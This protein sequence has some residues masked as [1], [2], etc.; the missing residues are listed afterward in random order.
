[1]RASRPFPWTTLDAV[2]RADVEVLPVVRRA[3]T[4]L[5]DPAA[6]SAA[7]RAL[8]GECELDARLRRV[9]S[10]PPRVEQSAVGMLLAPAE[11]ADRSSAIVVVLEHALAGALAARALKRQ[12]PRVVDPERQSSAA[13][14]GAAAAVLVAAARR[15]GRAPL[16][17]L[18]AGGAHAVLGELVAI[19][20]N[21]VGVTLTVLLDHDAYLAHA[22]FPRQA[23]GALPPFELDVRGLAGLGGLPVELRLVAAVVEI[24]PDDLAALRPGDALV[25]GTLSIAPGNIGF[26]GSVL[27]VAPGSEVCVRADLGEDGRVVLR[28]GPLPLV[29]S[30]E[31][32][33]DMDKDALAQAVGQSPLVLR[34]EVGAVQLTAREWAALGPGDVI[35]TGKRVGDA[36]VLRVGN[37]EVARGELVDIE[38]EI[39]VR[40]VSRTEGASS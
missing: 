24:S 6:A 28:D 29:P 25:V 14:A 7:L 33:S 2:R 3:V 9:S 11:R 38:G 12:A 20:P 16:R 26:A 15:D 8:V 36:V 31:E 10:S 5:V 19:D 22:F 17:V 4:E 23:L 34:V 40:I 35:A 21:P 39:G 37:A 27:L 32:R 30:S 1:M 13:L 18:T